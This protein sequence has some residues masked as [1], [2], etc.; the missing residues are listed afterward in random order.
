M[1]INFLFQ[2]S[3][4]PMWVGLV[5]SFLGVVALLTAAYLVVRSTT[6]KQTLEAQKELLATR[7]K[8]LADAIKEKEDAQSDLKAL[9]LEYKTIVGIDVDKLMAYWARKERE[10]ID[11]EEL[12]DENA[13]LVTR[14][15][16]GMLKE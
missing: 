4:L 12:R 8:Q 16:R 10:E 1:A 3:T 6:L 5:L 15:G 14:L 9:S 13:R 2:F 7:D 11:K